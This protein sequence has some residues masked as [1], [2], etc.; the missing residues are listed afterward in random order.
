[1]HN[2]SRL[3]EGS[4]VEESVFKLLPSGFAFLWEEC[5]RCYYESVVLGLQRPRSLMPKIFT[6]IHSKMEGWSKG[7]RT[8]L[9]VPG[10]PGGVVEVGEKWVQS[11]PIFIPGRRHQCFIRGKFDTIVKFDDG[12]Y[13][14]I[15]FKTC[16]RRDEHLPLYARQLHAYCMALENPAEGKFSLSP[17]SRVGLLVWEP[18]TFSNTEDETMALEGSFTWVEL[19][20]DVPGFMEF[21]SEVLYVLEQPTPPEPSPTCQWCRYRKEVEQ[22]I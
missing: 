10:M 7:K 13:G 16:H 9:L 3:H 1:M 4:H 14:V 21:L 5:H 2:K 6:Q 8:E 19:P 11:E 18:D 22:A 15:D 17:I 12:T 20:F